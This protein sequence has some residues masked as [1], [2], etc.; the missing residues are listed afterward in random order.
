[1]QCPSCG[2]ENA[3]DHRFCAGCGASLLHACPACSFANPFGARFCGGCG[4][5]LGAAATGGPPE[6][7]ARLPEGERRQVTILFADLCGFTR[8]S[9]ELDPEE[10][11]ALLEQY[12]AAVDGIV[13]RFGG[14]VDKHV[15]DC[16][17]AVFGA[18]VAHGDDPERAVR[19]ALALH[20]AVEGLSD[21]AGRP[22]AAHVGMASGSVV[23]SSTGSAGHRSYTVTGEAA[24]LAA[25][26]TDMAGAGETLVSDAVRRA[27]ADRMDGESVG[28]VAL[29][30]IERPVRV[31]RLLGLHE[32][33]RDGARR[34]FVGRRAELAQVAGA[35]DT[36]RET[37]RGLTVYLRGE[38][39]IGKTRL[40][41]QFRRLAGRQGFACHTGLVLDFGAGR[42]R[43][44]IRSL[45]RSL[46]DVGP[47]AGEGELRQAAARALA[48]GLIEPDQ[49]VYLND[50]LD[51]SQPLEARALYDAMDNVVRNRG[52]RATAAEVVRR[53]ALRRP[54]LLVI[55]DLHWADPE[56]LARAAELAAAVAEC[57]AVLVLTSRIEGDPLVAAWRGTT[58]GAPLLTI[59]LGPLRPEEAR[60]L[61][62]AFT[63]AGRF[64]AACVERSGGHPLFLEQLLRNVE[65]SGAEAL[66]GSVQSVVL[67]RMDALGPVDRQ[68]LQAASVLGKRFSLQA[69]RHLTSNP[70]YDAAGLVAH[71]LVQPEGDDLLFAHALI[72]EGV[73]ASLLNARRRE[74]HRRAAAWHAPRDPVLAAEHLDRAEDPAAAGAYLQAA[75]AEAQAYRAERALA[76]VERGL[77]L[78]REPAERFALVCL[79]GELLHDLGA[80]EP[81][82]A[83]WE[84][85]CAMAEGDVERCRAR[86]GLAAGLRVVDRHEEALELLDEAEA[87]ARA[88]NLLPEL[89]QLYHLRG[90]LCFMLGRLA[91]CREQHER[92]LDDARRLASPELEARA[93]GGLGDAAYAEGRMITAHGCFR[94]CVELARRHGFGR[95]EVANLSMVA[96]TRYYAIDLAG[97]LDDALAA[98]AAAARVGHQRAEVIAQHAAC[99]ALFETGEL[100]RARSHV[101]RAEELARHLGSRR[102][103]AEDLLLW[104]KIHLEQG[105]MDEARAAVREALAISRATGMDYL[106]PAVLGMIALATDDAG[107]RRSA[108]AEGEALL[109]HGSLSHNHLW[110]YRA[111]I[112]AALSAGDWDTAERHAAMLEAYTAGEPLPW[113][114]FCI[115]RARALAEFG[116]GRRDE[117][118]TRTLR[119]LRESAERSGMRVDLQ[120][121]DRALA[122]A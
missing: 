11:H 10:V 28:E 105:R 33:D 17:M 89:A 8:L 39:G 9:S 79:Q 91:A 96:I 24:N 30:G 104:A 5:P 90:N 56:T 27:L 78:V 103:E 20:V 65:E 114:D 50:L 120:A 49:T 72:Q 101:G 93:L 71:Y 77:A 55:E 111:G 66:P 112:E 86:L 83:A 25:R 115:A 1:M 70:G 22:L 63:A 3:A 60:V 87:A 19:A 113:A 81:C 92:A 32:P 116:R 62:G 47:H 88:Q 59:D 29:K 4:A 18:P 75:R 106:G 16:V 85:A 44:A 38:A 95:I 51:L 42:G 57:P 13:E 45:V 46:L 74:L 53:I 52:K 34:P 82:I 80:M 48:D 121:L 119:R 107:E 6:S 122:S 43:D 54:L 7:S 84:R 31:W 2:F 14:S 21:A 58:R 102:F 64:L 40:V 110:F 94:A 37:G 41:E 35:I 23:A 69:L 68:A 98:I 99:F 73:Y 12:F 97:M 118:T 61:A 36:C 108:L 109:R 117:T 15:G 76:L 26:L 100:E 67:A